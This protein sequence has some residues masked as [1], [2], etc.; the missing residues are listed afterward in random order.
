MGFYA[1]A[2]I[3]GDARK[4]GVEVR[5]IDV[6][7]SR[8]DC[9][10]ELS[11][12][13]YLAVR[14]G[15]R[16]ARELRNEDGAAI[17]LAR[18]NEPYDSVE[19]IQRRAGVSGRALDRIGQAGGFGSLKLSRRKGLWE[20]KGLGAP[21]LPLFAAAD[22]RAGKLRPE[23]VEPEVALPQMGD[24]E[25]VVED[26]RAVGLSLRA[27]P[28]SFLRDE[29]I[30]RKMITC[31]DLRDIKDGRWVNLAGLVLLRQRPGSAK[32][33]MFI[34]LED[35]TDVANLVV[36]TKVF[37]KHRRTVL[38][39]SMMGVRGQVQK[40]GE[41]IHVIAQQL[42]DLSGLVASV[43]NRTDIANVY[44]VSR[45]DIVKSAMTPDSRDLETHHLRRNPRG[46]HAPDL[47][48]G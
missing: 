42:D 10:L 36:W 33:V 14:M 19:E 29:L 25:E 8:W 43:G 21:A 9:S 48:L 24:G 41:V 35:E 28:L 4:H 34:T 30:S 39:A 31:A 23:A 17:V 7:H 44:Q 5:P 27:H 20:V 26:Y 45:A 12:G 3:V 6:N 46:L 47:R 38:G 13:P 11:S 18:G 16:Y 40:E 37:E 15:L 1:P 22:E 2:Q 32:G